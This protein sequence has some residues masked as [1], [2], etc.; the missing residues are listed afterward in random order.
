MRSASR[1]WQSRAGEY[2]YEDSHCNPV[3]YC[4]VQAASPTG[5]LRLTERASVAT[6][7]DDGFTESLSCCLVSLR[8]KRGAS[9]CCIVQDDVPGLQ[10]L[11]ARH[12]CNRL[13]LYQLSGRCM[14]QEAF[15]VLRVEDLLG[16]ET[17][18]AAVTRLLD[19]ASSLFSPLTD[20]AEAAQN[21]SPLQG[22][23]HRAVALAPLLQKVA[24]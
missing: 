15:A 1:V 12:H 5:F 9:Y 13:Y 16:S 10:R 3:G 21:L 17:G 4:L 24:T 7:D 6:N 20:A 18:R 11:P 2:L 22:Q 23:E 19:T 8:A 14:L